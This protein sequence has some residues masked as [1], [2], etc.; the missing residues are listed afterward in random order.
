MK[1]VIISQARMSSTRLPGKV[2]KEVLGKPLLEYHI[3]RLKRTKKADEIIIA[4]TVN[5]ADEPI[6]ELCQRLN[7]LCY[8]GSEEDV[9]S[10]YYYAACEARADVVIRVTSDCPLIDPV[11]VDQVIEAFTACE[12]YDYVA[13]TLVRTYPRGMDTE[14]FS[15][16]AL[17]RAFKE[18]VAAPERE[19][20]TPYIYNHPELFKFKNIAYTTDQSRHRW[21]VDTVDDFRLIEK[22]LLELYPDKPDFT[23]EDVLALFDRHPDWYFINAHVEQKKF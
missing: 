12:G 8:R 14:V 5:S 15:F 7:V 17:E 21:T 4:T 10:R 19:H 20:V 18:A 11:V 1:T 9:L 6:A 3:E 23:M 2:L 16:V 13:N 22:I